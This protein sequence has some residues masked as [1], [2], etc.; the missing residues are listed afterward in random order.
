MFKQS[1]LLE[2]L[3]FIDIQRKADMNVTMSKVERE[4]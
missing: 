4:D 1:S 2:F 3:F